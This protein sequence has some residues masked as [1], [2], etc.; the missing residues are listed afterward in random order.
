LA[1]LLVLAFAGS[2]AAQERTVGKWA[3]KRLSKSHEALQA[4]KYKDALGH[5]DEM[6]ARSRLNDHERALMWQTY[7]F[8]Y[9]GQERFKEAAAAFESCLALKALPEGAQ[10][11]TQYNLGQLYLSIGQVRKA[12]STLESWFEVAK[13]PAP[14]AYFVMAMAYAQTKAFRNGLQFAQIAVSRVKNPQ[15]SWLQLLLSMHFELK[16][17]KS[18]AGVLKR[19]VRKLPHKKSYWMQLS[20]VYNEI[21]DPRRALAVMELAYRQGFL[22]KPNELSNLAQFYLQESVP[23]RAAEIVEKGFESGMLQRDYKSLRLLATSL[24]YARSFE[25]A[26]APLGAAAKLSDEGELYLQK[27]QLH[28]AREEWKEAAA[29]GE[30]AL[31]KKLADE[32]NA[33]LLLG[34]VYFQASKKAAA[35]RQFEKAIRFKKTKRPAQQW[36]RSMESR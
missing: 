12:V 4:E 34:I 31:E 11:N 19:L 25:R 14:T 32:G 35:R 30:A 33:H 26:F 29:A 10:L 8:I 1:V 16:E 22:T 24:V 5:M 13:N 17:Y 23:L 15:E 28:M 27:A 18:A 9:S 21:G 2:A 3:F 36:L 6:K 20:A 7:G